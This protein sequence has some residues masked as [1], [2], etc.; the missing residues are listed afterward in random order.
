MYNRPMTARSRSAYFQALGI[1]V[2]VRRGMHRGGPPAG[3]TQN[4]DRTPTQPDSPMRAATQ[5]SRQSSAR[6]TVPRGPAPAPVQPQADEAFRVRCFH[7]GRVF[8]AL[9]GD[10]WP[11][12]RFLYDVAWALNGF[13]RSERRDLVFD[14]PQPGAV[15]GGGAKAFGAFV[16]HQTRTRE[17]SRLLVS[18]MQ[19][20]ALL[21][22]GVPDESCVL[23]TR[24]YVRP[25]A[26]NGADKRSIWRLIQAMSESA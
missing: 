25:D 5:R 22:L 14:W 4:D 19:V 7:Y 11:T 9:G 20:A 24:L 18:G 8:A 2:W 16:R 6:H 21:G 23:D 15:A 12:R 3:S 17:G 10:A 26:L 1:D 13:E